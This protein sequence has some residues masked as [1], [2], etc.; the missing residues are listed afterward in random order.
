MDRSQL[1]SL[2]GP[3]PLGSIYEGTHEI[4]QRNP[5]T[6]GLQTLSNDKINILNDPL[7]KKVH[8][9]IVS[10][11]KHTQEKIEKTQ[12]KKSQN[13]AD[14]HTNRPNNH[15]EKSNI[16]DKS[17]KKSVDV[18]I[19]P[20]LR[21]LVQS[22]LYTTTSSCS[23]RITFFEKDRHYQTKNDFI[24]GRS[25]RFLYSSHSYIEQS[26]FDDIL[27][28]IDSNPK[29]KFDCYKSEHEEEIDNNIQ[30]SQTNCTHEHVY[31]ENEVI[32]KFE[33]FI[34][35]V[36]CKNIQDGRKLM[37]LC[38]SVGLKQSGISSFGKKIIVA[39]RGNGSLEAPVMIK[40][41]R[42]E[43]NLPHLLENQYLVNNEYLIYLINCCNRK[44]ITNFYQFIRLYHRLKEEIKCNE[45]ELKKDEN[46]II[47]YPI[48]PMCPNWL[49]SDKE[50]TDL[51][52]DGKL[53]YRSTFS[54][55]FGVE[56][57]VS[58]LSFSENSKHLL[59][60]ECC[61]TTSKR[62]VVAYGGVER[63]ISKTVCVLD[64]KN[65]D[66]GFMV[67]DLGEHGPVS[68]TD[69]AM[70]CDGDVFITHGGMK[71]IKS[72]S[73]EVYLLHV[74]E[75]DSGI[76]AVKWY[77][78]EV[79][80]S[81]VP[82]PRYR[83]SMCLK[84]RT[85]IAESKD[86]TPSFCTY[87]TKFFVAGGLSTVYQ[88]YD[89]HCIWTCT[90][91]YKISGN[92]VLSP[93]VEWTCLHL[94]TSDPWI[95]GSLAYQEATDTL[96][97]I[98]GFKSFHEPYSEDE[99]ITK[100]SG[101]DFK[102]MKLINFTTIP[103][104]F[105]KSGNNSE[106]RTPGDKETNPLLIAK[107]FP[108]KRIIHRLIK[109]TD[110]DYLLVGRHAIK[111][112]RCE[113]WYFNLREFVWHKS[114][115][116]DSGAIRG[117]GSCLVRYEKGNCKHLELWMAG[118]GIPIGYTIGSV[119]DPPVRIILY[120][121]N[122]C[123]GNEGHECGNYIEPPF[124]KDSFKETGSDDSYNYMGMYIVLEN[125]SMLKKIKTLCEQ[126]GA[127]DKSRKIQELTHSNKYL[128]HYSTC[129][130]NSDLKL[131]SRCYER[132]R[133][134][135]C[136][137]C[138]SCNRTKY[139]VGAP[140]FLVPVLRRFEH[141]ELD[142]AP[143]FNIFSNAHLNKKA[144]QNPKDKLLSILK[145]EVNESEVDASVMGTALLITNSLRTP[146]PL[147]SIDWKT[148]S[149]EFNVQSVA[150]AGEI[151]GE[152]RQRRI[153]LLYGPEEVSVK[154]NGVTYRFNITKN[155]FSKGNS[156]E[157]IRLVK[158]YFDQQAKE[159]VQTAAS[160]KSEL[161]V[162]LFCGIGYFS[163][164]ILKFT[165]K[166]RVSKIVCVDINDEAIK[167]IN[168]N[169]GSNKI[170]K[171]RIETHLEDCSKFGE[172]FGLDY[173]GKADRILL[174][175]LPSSEVGWIPA[176]RALNKKVGGI[177]HI[178]GLT[179]CKSTFVFEVLKSSESWESYVVKHGYS[180]S[181][182]KGDSIGENHVKDFGLYT[183]KRFHQLCNSLSFMK[184]CCWL[185]EVLHIRTVKHYS[186][187][188]YHG[189]VDL[190]LTPISLNS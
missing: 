94:S 85:L 117:F 66:A 69:S 84:K 15:L 82:R 51:F 155:M 81:T 9:N 5:N 138:S 147:D 160:T 140:C 112:C 168:I 89:E 36:E 109:M 131:C 11:L 3:E 83:H 186:P 6:S 162:D 55:P 106:S 154:E 119:Y 101:L 175:L 56:I 28:L 98:G 107:C 1:N 180:G 76:T 129:N 30:D 188:M 96:F 87:E 167:Y 99:Y 104:R 57:P 102:S 135:F 120:C 14:S 139:V 49:E 189:V 20:L 62:Y 177:L 68:T 179:E 25:G 88:P 40:K 26:A 142:N 166:K 44:M 80:G 34:V 79:K 47:R 24:Y 158:T 100:I 173:V 130:D 50:Y 148:V 39:I 70:I 124:D 126:H 60:T 97:F 105:L 77:K 65:V 116:M 136:H 78:C 13:G 146:F 92:A 71:N 16:L 86:S 33:P 64:L 53:K 59:R 21:L 118:G 178:H 169:C 12:Y 145:S 90:L 7:I 74:Y 72:D 137:G 128:F 95:R 127:F 133:C 38:K 157:R 52:S 18:F 159:S 41:Y 174:G 93:M 141:N 115:E 190:K 75:E 22:G 32:L 31:T 27:A 29:S 58:V 170:D 176:L 122:N 110:D 156:Y 151:E 46:K 181:L 150:L 37:D 19:V 8:D 63:G 143:T 103:S 48:G 149:S 144:A 42:I 184:H 54:F 121:N 35:H 113:V 10:A 161:I 164:P 165:D 153:E 2:F 67:F 152:K 123:C 172:T 114:F 23:G 171:D 134:G 111:D 73:N 108:N 183:L 132:S 187:N 182:N 125:Q 45:Q 163:V 61:L 4:S 91:T 43:N 185:L 17:L